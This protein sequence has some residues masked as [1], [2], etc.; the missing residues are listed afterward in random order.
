M[1]GNV[2][3]GKIVITAP[4]ASNVFNQVAVSAGK[5]EAGL[6]RLAPASNSANLALI[7][8]GRVVQDLPFG[9]LGIANNLNP[10]LESFQRLKAETGSTG[11]ALQGLK[12]SLL[13]AGGIGFALSLVSSALIVFGDR[14]FGAKAQMTSL[15][16]VFS[17]A[18][19]SFVN[20]YKAVATLSSEIDLAKQGLISKEGVV[21]SYNETIGKTTGLVTSL[22]EAEAGLIANSD[23]YIQMMLNKSVAQIAYGKAAEKAFKIEENWQK[24]IDASGKKVMVL[25]VNIADLATNKIS[26]QNKALQKS[27]DLYKKIG[28][29]ATKAAADAAKGFNFFGDN[30]EIKVPKIK[31]KPDKI[32]LAK[33]GSI[34]IELDPILSTKGPALSK[35]KESVLRIQEILNASPDF[36]GLEVPIK[37]FQNLQSKTNRGIELIRQGEID[38]LKGL[39]DT[40]SGV[41]TPAFQGFFDTVKGGGNAFKAFA[42]AAGQAL[43]ALIEKLAIAAILSLILS[44]ITGAGTAIGAASGKFGDIFKFLSGFGGARAGGGP[45]QGGKSYLV[46]ERGAE[47]FM[48]NTGGRIIPNNQLGGATGI[49]GGLSISGVVTNVLR[50]KDL[51]Q[52]ITLQTQSNN[53]LI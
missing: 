22:E 48:P 33:L 45:V 7:N 14:I 21:K 29:G 12:K 16:R 5:A 23:A 26:N 50:G 43:I 19:D 6:K 2:L 49:S 52:L 40:I 36:K 51:L 31:I 17:E 9:F 38:R 3:T 10:L 27:V 1:A 24:M 34:Q 20:A 15:Q 44:S 11:A 53:R 42:Q 37:A 25:G 28:D 30:K 35:I 46:G 18:K 39:A 47:I 32:E 41:L 13:G 8:T 4:G